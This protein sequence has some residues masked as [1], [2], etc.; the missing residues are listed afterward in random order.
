MHVSLLTHPD[1][2]LPWSDTLAD[3]SKM[4]DHRP[5]P[6]RQVSIS[7]PEPRPLGE[8][9]RE[10]RERGRERRRDSVTMFLSSLH[11]EMEPTNQDADRKRND[12]RKQRAVERQYS[13]ETKA[14]HERVISRLLSEFDLEE[15]KDKYRT[16][17]PPDVVVPGNG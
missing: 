5:K 9:S 15:T 8:V 3:A 13:D 1:L 16:S 2:S 10:R 4:A 12:G 17:L 7:A 6:T 14:R 11:L